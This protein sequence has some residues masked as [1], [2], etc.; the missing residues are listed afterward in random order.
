[1]KKLAFILLGAFLT[2]FSQ[3]Q[4]YMLGDVNKDGEVNIAD[5]MMVVDIIMY[6]YTPLSSN[7]NAVSVYVGDSTAIEIVG[8]YD[9]YEVISANTEIATVSISGSTITINGVTYGET[10]ITVK[11]L[12]TKRVLNIPVFVA[13]DTLDIS[14]N[15]MMLTVGNE[16]KIVV[17]STSGNFHI[18]NGDENVAGTKVDK[19]TVIITAKDYG[20][21]TI[22]VNDIK[23]KRASAIKVTVTDE[24]GLL[25]FLTCPDSKH[26]HMIDLGLPSGTKWAC[27][28]V[29]PKLSKNHPSN[30]GGYYA[31]GETETKDIYDFAHYIHCN[32]TYNTCHNLGND[33]A[34]TQYDVAHMK[35][36]NVWQMPTDVQRDEMFNNCTFKGMAINGTTG[37]LFTG[38]SGNNIFLPA[39]GQRHATDLEYPNKYG[40]YW[41][42]TQSSRFPDFANHFAI[43]VV[44]YSSL[45][46]SSDSRSLG[47]CVRPISK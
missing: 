42:S 13:Y 43:Y 14:V 27:C 20:E 32:G 29:D 15:E 2:N 4:S 45:S 22:I 9:S 46:S 26:P 1:M 24:S 12:Q 8:G 19:D 21:T 40:F 36:G 34:G 31:W 10:S 38:P 11:D 28:N 6:G 47:F 17:T 35:W 16:G 30:P 3:A 7:P 5:A 44:F 33:I 41:T 39:A 37:Y 25:K 18:V 23:H